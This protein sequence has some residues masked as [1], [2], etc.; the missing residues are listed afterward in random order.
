MLD[1][2]VDVA[3]ETTIMVAYTAITL[4]LAHQATKRIAWLRRLD[5]RWQ[6][7]RAIADARLRHPAAR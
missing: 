4:T 2:I 7:E 5:D 3:G 6:H 1:A